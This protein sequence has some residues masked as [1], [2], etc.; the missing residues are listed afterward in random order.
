MNYTKPVLLYRKIKR[1]IREYKFNRKIKREGVFVPK[2]YKTIAK[3][4]DAGETMIIV[5]PDGEVL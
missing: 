5:M 4:M 2:D 1:I 3:A